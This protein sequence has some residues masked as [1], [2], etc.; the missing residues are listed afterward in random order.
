MNKI[1]FLGTGAGDE[2][3]LLQ[4]VRTSCI[5]CELD[6]IKFLIDPGPGT[7]VNLKNNGINIFDLNGVLISHPHPDHYTDA[8]VVLTAF[9]HKDAFLI[10]EETCLKGNQDFFPCVSK[11]HQ[12]H[13]AKVFPMKPNDAVEVNGLKVTAVEAKHYSPCVGFTIEGTKKISYVAD[14]IYSEDNCKNFKNSDIMIL[15]TYIPFESEAVSEYYFM[16]K[17]GVLHMSVE[18]AIEIVKIAK[19]KLAV[20][21]H[22]NKKF[23]EAKPEKQAEIIEKATETKTIAAED[24]MEINLDSLEVEK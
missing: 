24:S 1:I 14:G 2:G 6:K 13:T 15:N 4:L 18:D 5:Y 23:L 3:M 20:I 9:Y 21:Q 7:L 12:S 8:N 11:F 16:R 17:H 22:Y 10:A 19:P